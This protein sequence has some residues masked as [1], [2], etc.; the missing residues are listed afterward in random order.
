MEQPW[1]C[2][3]WVQVVLVKLWR[4]LGVIVSVFKQ[5]NDCAPWVR[6]TG[7]I[8]DLPFGHLIDN[9]DYAWMFYDQI[10][11]IAWSSDV[12]RHSSLENTPSA[13]MPFANDNMA[14]TLVAHFSRCKGRCNREWAES[15]NGIDNPRC[16][17]QSTGAII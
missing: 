10:C 9:Q 11:C 15:P 2:W 14:R 13:I 12:S 6:P 4:L 16:R 8:H 17:T 7:L 1:P 5:G 3:T